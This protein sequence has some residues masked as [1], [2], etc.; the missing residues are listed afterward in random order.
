MTIRCLQRISRSFMNLSKCA[1]ARH[2]THR[3]VARG[4]TGAHS[5][6]MTTRLDEALTFRPRVPSDDIYIHALSAGA[7]AEYARS[8]QGAVRMLVAERDA[9]TEVAVIDG[10]PVG[11]AIVSLRRSPTAYGPVGKAWVAHLSAI[12]A[13]P[14]MLR[15]GIGRTLLARAEQIARDNGAVCMSLTTGVMNA[16]ARALFSGEGYMS[17]AGVADFY[18]RGQDAVFMH[19]SL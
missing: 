13:D 2:L 11:F 8:G 16:R 14:M 12:A 10:E 4:S 6:H 9:F 7:F 17:L 5:E 18:R 3:G 19:K 1:S 15:R